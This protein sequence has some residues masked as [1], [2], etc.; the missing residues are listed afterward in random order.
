MRPR[1]SFAV[2][3][4]DDGLLL[5]TYFV[6]ALIAGQ[7]TARIRAQERAERQREQRATALF[8]LT[9]ALTG[10]RTLDEAV[11]AA[12]R[13][14]DELFSAQTALLLAGESGRP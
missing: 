3:D 13:Q 9:R 10:A 12:L 2:L 14:A 11:T 7:L 8:N 1:F 4:F 5:G 6:V